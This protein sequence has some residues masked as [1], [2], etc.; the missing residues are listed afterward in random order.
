V[1][2]LA[3]EFRKIRAAL[4]RRFLLKLKRATH[5]SQP[6]LITLG[7]SE[8]MVIA[9]HMDDEIIG[10]GGTLLRLIE[11]GANVH[12]VFTTDSSAAVRDASLRRQVTAARRAEALRVRDYAGFA[13]ITELG[14]PDGGL[15]RHEPKLS[16][17]LAEEFSRISPDTV[18]CPYP[19][20]GHGDHMSTAWATADAARLGGWTCSIVA[21]EVW[22]PM[23]PNICVDITSVADRKAT[24]I[25]LYESQV[26]NR[27]YASAALGLNRF[28]GL[29]HALAYAEAFHKSDVHG[30]QRLAAL[31]DEL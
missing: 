6:E 5:R 22:T 15:S 12:I 13:G 28:R 11:G 2:K 3:N 20:D 8:V 27:D 7:A 4:A 21:Y 10:C 30:Y 9:P 14:F 19:G 18:F 26:E 1:R 25:R 17:R 23:W 16:S 24:A 29:P 31:L